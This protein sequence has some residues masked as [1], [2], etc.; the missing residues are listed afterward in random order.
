MAMNGLCARIGKG[1]NRRI[2]SGQSSSLEQEM[3]GMAVYGC[4]ARD[5]DC[6]DRK[7]LYERSGG[8]LGSDVYVTMYTLHRTCSHGQCLQ[9]LMDCL[10]Y[11][12][13]ALSE[14]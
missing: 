5:S 2:C 6:R 12:S 9:G 11:E 8:H 4:N 7:Y 10:I 13:D 3:A 1:I 14:I